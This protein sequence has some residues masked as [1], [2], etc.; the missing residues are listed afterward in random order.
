[1]FSSIFVCSVFFGS[2]CV[3]V[4]LK[5]WKIASAPSHEELFIRHYE[6]LLG[7]AIQLTGRNRQQAE[8]L[9]HDVFVQFALLQP[10]LEGIENLEGYLFASMRN[11]LRS[12]MRRDARR[13]TARLSLV[14]Y[15]SAEIGLRAV[16]PRADLG[17]RDELALIC[18]Y[19]C[20][21]K[22]T[23]KAGSALILRYFLGYYPGEIAL[24]LRSSRQ[25]VADLLGAARREARL[26]LDQPQRLRFMREHPNMGITDLRIGEQSGDLIQELRRAIFRSCEGACWT[27]KELKDIC[28]R[29]GAASI[30][31]KTL[32]HIVSCS[33]CLDIVNRELGLPLLA[34]RYPTDTL[35]PDSG[36]GGG[37]V[38]GSGGGSAGDRNT[39]AGESKM[40]GN[41]SAES[42]NRFRS[43][44]R[45]VIEHE[46]KE[47]HIAV[48]GQ[49]LGSQAVNADLNEQNL[50]LDEAEKIGFI[51][52]FSEQGIRLVSLSVEPPP[53]G[54]FKRQAQVNLSEER[55]IQIALEFGGS[56]ANLKV[57]YQH[58]GY[59]QDVAAG[60]IPE[61]FGSFSA[62]SA[63]DEGDRDGR[64]LFGGLRTGWG[65]WSGMGPGLIATAVALLFVVALIAVRMSSRPVLAAELLERSEAN[66]RA[67]RGNPELLLHRVVELEER[68][69]ALDRVLSRRRVEIWQSAAK[70]VEV[71]RAYDEQGKLLAGEWRQGD[72]SRT[73]LYPGGESFEDRA[74]NPGGARSAPRS[75]DEAWRL[76]LSAAAFSALIGS[77]SA[78]TVEERGE[79]Y[80]LKFINQ[81][82]GQASIAE[83]RS[84]TLRLGR[85]GLRALEQTLLVESDLGLREYRFSEVRFDRLGLGEVS[86]R[87][88]DREPM[89]SKP[90]AVEAKVLKPDPPAGDAAAR[91]EVTPAPAATPH[92]YVA[93]VE[94]EIEALVLLDAVGATLGEEVSV[95]RTLDGTL[96]IEGV[97]E[98]AERKNAI[99]AAL[100]PIHRHR[101]V[102]V[103]IETPEEAEHRLEQMRS[104]AVAVSI[105]EAAPL[106]S[107]IPVDAELRRYLT[108]LGVAPENLDEEINRFANRML[109]GS[110]QA[111]LYAW[112]LRNL[113]ERFSPAELQGLDPQ[114]RSK[115]LGLIAEH[116]AG[117]RREIA[118]MRRDLAP[119][120]N[121]QA[122]AERS[123]GEADREMAGDAGLA[124]AVLAFVEL[125]AGVDEQIRTAFTLSADSA[126][127]RRNSHS[128]ANPEFR[129]RLARAEALAERISNAASQL[130]SI[131]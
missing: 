52:V 9:V 37:G 129:N 47:L 85:S 28:S 6:Q 112:S 82:S 107:R 70:G 101:A 99:L 78:A 4:M 31:G 98:N 92:V 10:P 21:R 51:E 86:S 17:V 53:G 42:I 49:V 20:V 88:F 27:K 56:G 100:D 124:R 13:T 103:R 44:L 90:E 2:S 106:A 115:W 87:V 30:A 68:D 1:L 122:G 130:R 69:A 75:A 8:D 73:L 119:V 61:E 11:L 120:F 55:T 3:D 39:G 18:H 111:L 114:A 60:E 41:F 29:A 16:D 24:I 105:Q 77:S 48:N 66:D 38:G 91:P 34:E 25:A 89:L 23:S 32:S 14:D 104:T 46:P 33:R 118:T 43:R 110:R 50:H 131:R 79:S 121:I 35:G 72:G 123:A 45:D 80:L 7:W 19:A 57:I 76:D 125:S 71:R 26:Y 94:L 62:E 5:R 64:S 127:G 40:S 65:S 58:P 83:L 63:V 116:S 36:D 126:V 102:R 109:R 67:A 81:S 97:V 117:Y 96:Q 128:F 12:Q 108:S 113:V 59:K 84:A 22:E 54:P 95:T 15:D 93:T 74:E